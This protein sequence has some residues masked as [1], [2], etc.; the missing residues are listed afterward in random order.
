MHRGGFARHIAD[1][2]RSAAQMAARAMVASDCRRRDESRVPQSKH[3]GSATYIGSRLGGVWDEDQTGRL[4][5]TGNDGGDETRGHV[6]RPNEANHARVVRRLGEDRTPAS[7][8]LDRVDDVL[9]SVCDKQA[10]RAGCGPDRVVLLVAD[11]SLENLLIGGAA[12]STTLF[13]SVSIRQ[14]QSGAASSSSR[15]TRRPPVERDQASSELARSCRDLP[16]V[17][18]TGSAGVSTFG[19]S[20]ECPPVGPGRSRAPSGLECGPTLARRCPCRFR[21]YPEADCRAPMQVSPWARGR[22]GGD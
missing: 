19:S 14:T 10:P 16:P 2:H 7:A 4:A 12:T 18:R 20:A 1:L 9:G 6:D 21:L 8:P 5:H 22:R 15:A 11:W 3:S 13:P 17:G